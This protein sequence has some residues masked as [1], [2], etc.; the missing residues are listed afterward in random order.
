MKIEFLPPARDELT[1]AISYYNT[2][3]EGLGYEFA[4][5][6]DFIEIP[7][8]TGDEPRFLVIGKILEKHWSAIITFR[9]GKVRMF[10]V[11]RF[12]KEEVEI[13]EG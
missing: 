12:R 6:V 8:K 3:S 2:Q 5:E 9:D 10:S 7:L 4:A 1:D 13:Y 11:R